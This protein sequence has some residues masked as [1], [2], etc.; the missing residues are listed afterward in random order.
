MFR[1]YRG[2]GLGV[3]ELGVGGCV[4]VVSVEYVVCLPVAFM[5]C[6]SWA[7]YGFRFGDVLVC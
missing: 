1:G 2:V 6:A 7:R 4:Y 5:L 3:R